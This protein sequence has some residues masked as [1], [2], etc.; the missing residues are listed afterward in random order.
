MRRIVITGPESTGKTTLA[1]RLALELG[2]VAVPEFARDYLVQKGA[3]LDRHD[4]EVIAVG[5]LAQEDRH[6]R[7]AEGVLILDTDLFSTVVYGA[8]YYGAVEPWIERV[9]V[10]RQGDLYLLLDVDVPW[11]A[12][13]ARDRESGRTEMHAEFRVMLEKHALRCERIGGGWAERTRRAVEVV[14]EGRPSG[15]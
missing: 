14:R 4:V 8:H 7:R 5:H 1:A 15:G 3:P 9:A 13:P 11:V 6:A 2:T 12:D 10:E